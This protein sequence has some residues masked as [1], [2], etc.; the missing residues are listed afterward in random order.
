MSEAYGSIYSKQESISINEG[1][2]MLDLVSKITSSFTT[3]YNMYNPLQESTV[4]FIAQKWS[5]GQLGK[6][7]LERTLGR[8]RTQ[9]NKAVTSFV[10]YL[11]SGMYDDNLKAFVKENILPTISVA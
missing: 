2:I 7:L 9:N 11:E 6:E 8:A 1:D 10:T 3:M 5:E 4:R